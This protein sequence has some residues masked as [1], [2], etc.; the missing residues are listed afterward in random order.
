MRKGIVRLI[1]SLF[2]SFLGLSLLILISCGDTSGD[3]TATITLTAASEEVAPEGSTVITATVIRAVGVT[4]PAFGENVAFTLR[5]TANGGSLSP[6]TRKTDNM[7][8]AKTVYTAGNNYYSDTIQAT[9]D[10][11]T[12]DFIIIGKTAPPTP[13]SI[14]VVASP[15]SVS[16]GNVSKVTATVTGDDNVGVTVT[17][18]MPVNNSGANLSA[19]S[20]V[21][22]GSGKA[23][24][25][26]TAGANSPTLSVSDTVQASVSSV[27]DTVV[28]TRTGS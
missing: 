16:A 1:V 14:T 15:A 2:Y 10:N 12:S 9:L 3:P 25:T 19:S 17:F 6:P 8:E 4:G 20:A 24:V 27:S 11:G 23:V 13:L 28:I 21:T 18:T 22:D 7:G 5:T 26:Y